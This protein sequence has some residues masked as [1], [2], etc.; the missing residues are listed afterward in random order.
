MLDNAAKTLFHLLARSDTLKVMASR[1]GMRKPTS[2]ARRFIAGEAVQEA[3]EA[4][5]SLE[6]KGLM[7]TLDFL[8]EGVNTIG[9]AAAASQDYM[10]VID[11]IIPS[12]IGRNLSLKLSQLGLGV[13][14]AVATDNLRR[15]LDHA[16]GFFVR[17]DMESSEHTDSTLQVFETLWQQGY[18]DVGVVLQADLRRSEQDVE[19]MIALG[20]RVRLVKGAYRE[21][22]SVAFQRKSEV[23]AAFVRLLERLLRH[24][25]YPAIATHDSAMINSARRYVATQQ[26]SPDA[27]E[28][29]MLYGIR[30]DV[31]A[32][33]VA[34]GYQVRVY[35]PFGQQWFPYFMRRLGER[36]ANVGF[37]LRGIALDRGA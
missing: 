20:A 29:Q 16:L 4:A 25:H 24:G 30:R 35:I 6:A 26:I 11:A 28:F 2:F 33:L 13:D 9:D 3:I 12:G 7:Q 8:G 32:S 23:D 10:G 22:A 19:R 5:R 15:I 21:P 37:V 27:F 14:R 31:Q 17:I 1:Y 34:E 36:P 18:R